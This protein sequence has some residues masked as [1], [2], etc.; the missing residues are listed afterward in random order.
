LIG[1]NQKGP[2][3]LPEGSNGSARKAVREDFLQILGFSSFSNKNLL[4]TG[5]LGSWGG[6]WTTCCLIQSSVPILAF[7]LSHDVRC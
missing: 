5:L 1:M 3:L 6:C 2:H 4:I 7:H